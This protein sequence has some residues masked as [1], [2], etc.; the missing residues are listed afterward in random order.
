[1]KL[2]NEIY[3]YVENPIRTK[4]EIKQY[5]IEQLENYRYKFN[6]FEAKY[7][8]SL[9]REEKKYMLKEMFRTNSFF[10]NEL[11]EQTKNITEALVI[12][13]VA[14]EIC[15]FYGNIFDTHKIDFP[16][17][18]AAHIEIMFLMHQMVLDKELHSS[19]SKIMDDFMQHFHSYFLPIEIHFQNNRVMMKELFHKA[20]NRLQTHLEDAEP[21]NK[22]L[23]M[24]SRLKQLRHRELELK[25][26]EHEKYF[27]KRE[28]RYSKLFKEFLQ[29][30][31]E[32][33]NQTKDLNVIPLLS[34]RKQALLPTS[35]VHTF[36]SLFPDNK[37]IFVLKMLED[38]SITTNG[39][40]L[41]SE[42]RKGALRGI[43]S[44]LKENYILPDISN[45]ALCFAIAAKINL[46]LKSYP[47]D[48]TTSNDYRIQ[49][50]KYIKANL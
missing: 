17:K 19:M 11:E 44:A 50:T 48:S 3:E 6:D 45:T 12:Q 28:Y 4:K 27:N 18:D 16:G 47:N 37:G 36:D 24:Q 46:V 5:L 42:R 49:A 30:E 32:F 22:I 41:L 38:L 33:I 29:I 7:I 25:K 39:T 26:H 20:L 31:A 40:A 15:G 13:E 8:F 21:T 35:T 43:V 14:W 10:G 23:F 1:E 34:D 9:L 2:V